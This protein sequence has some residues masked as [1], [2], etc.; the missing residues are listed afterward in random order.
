[1]RRRIRDN[2]TTDERTSPKIPRRHICTLRRAFFDYFR[3]LQ[4]RERACIKCRLGMTAFCCATRRQRTRLLHHCAGEIAAIPPRVTLD[5]SFPSLS[6]LLF[7]FSPRVQR[8]SSL[9]V[10]GSRSRR[11]PRDIADAI[12]HTIPRSRVAFVCQLSCRRLDVLDFRNLSAL[13]QR[14]ARF[15][16]FLHRIPQQAASADILA[17]E[18]RGTSS[19]IF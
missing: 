3:S 1:M 6:P 2:V 7:R 5:S 14:S 13:R 4:T 9:L 18:S 16:F 12:L 19:V 17:Q 11:S 10:S 8:A 15:F